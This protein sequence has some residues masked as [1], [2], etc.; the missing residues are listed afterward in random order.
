MG[1][2]A[3]KFFFFFF[4]L[5]SHSASVSVLV[6]FMHIL[7]DQIQHVLDLVAV[8]P[9]TEGPFALARKFWLR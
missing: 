6:L 7:V 2:E 4:F 5:Y 8:L 3:T 9:D 1:Q